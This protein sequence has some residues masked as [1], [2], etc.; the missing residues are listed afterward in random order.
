MRLQS[1]HR[2]LIVSVLLFA[3]VASSASVRAP[4][5]MGQKG[6]EFEPGC[7]A[8]PLQLADLAVTNP[9]HWID[10]KCGIKGHSNVKDDDLR[11]AHLAQNATKNNYCAL[12]SQDEPVVVKYQAFVDLQRIADDFDEKEIPWGDR[13]SLPPDRKRLRDLLDLPGGGELGEGDVVTYVAWVQHASHSNVNGGEGVDCQATGC[14]NNDIHVSLVRRKT[15]S[16]CRSVVAE[17]SPHLRPS[18]WERFD[19]D[20]YV[21]YFSQH[22]VRMTGQLFFDA[23]HSPCRKVGTKSEVRS[24]PARIS[25]WEIHPVYAIDV[26]KNKSLSACRADDES[27]WVPFDQYRKHVGLKTVKPGKYWAS[28]KE[29]N[30]QCTN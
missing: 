4:R 23:S 9:Q 16:K 14:R 25:V 10:K 20:S 3:A 24:S 22:P 2:K 28:K 30:K 6:V 5:V 29:P 15:D 11:R 7:N 13:N 17:I 27:V 12:K 8:L 21:P 1:G 19:S 18:S 26:C